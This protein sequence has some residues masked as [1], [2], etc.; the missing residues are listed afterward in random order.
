MKYLSDMRRLSFVAVQLPSRNIIEAGS[1]ILYLGLFISKANT[2]RITHRRLY[3]HV[4]RLDLVWLKIAMTSKS[5]DCYYSLGN[6]GNP[7]ID[8]L[9]KKQA[10]I[11][12]ENDLAH[13]TLISCLSY[14]S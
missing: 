12:L 9:V 3:A 6:R 8:L 14:Y 5:L 11:L 1:G 4:E 2:H 10:L 13:E 7:F